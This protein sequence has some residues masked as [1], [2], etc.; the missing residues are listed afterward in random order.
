MSSLRVLERLLTLKCRDAATILSATLDGEVSR[1]D[2]WAMRLHM[3]V[4]SACRLYRR[5]TLLLRE[6]LRE[7]SGRLETGASRGGEHLSEGAKQR[8]R[9]MLEQA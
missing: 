3:M 1:S 2:R 9:E 6:L 5:Q 7:L 4:C 8:L